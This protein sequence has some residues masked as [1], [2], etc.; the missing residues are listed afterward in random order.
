MSRKKI[1]LIIILLLVVLGGI[2]GVYFYMNGNIKP[3][4]NE[5]VGGFG[6]LVPGE[7]SENMGEI[8]NT[9]SSSDGVIPRLR[10]I[11]RTPVAGYDFVDQG[12]GF[13]IWYVDRGN[14]NVFETATNTLSI[15]RITNTTI[16]KVYEAHIGKGGSNIIL[17]LLDN[18]NTNIQTFIG[19]PKA[20]AGAASSS[21]QTKDLVGTFGPSGINF[22]SLSPLKDRF[23][24]ITGN[25]SGG[26][27]S[28]YPY[29]GTAAN[30]FSH[31]LKKWIPQWVNTNTILLTSAP[32]SKTQNLAYFLN[33]S[34]KAVTKAIGPKNGLV[35][36]SSPDAAYLFYSHNIENNIEA[37]IYNVKLGTELGTANVTIPDKCVWSK[38][39]T[40]LAYCGFPKNLA[41]GSYPDSWYQGKVLFNDEIGSLDMKTGRFSSI[42]DLQDESGVQID[43]INLMLSKDEKYL[44]FTNKNDLT[45]WML[46]L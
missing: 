45:L 26:Q 2:A 12:T 44:L 17:R 25:T 4:D 32:S 14:G 3:A 18:D 33:T 29:L 31:P 22:I 27:G 41:G 38:F 23:F 5:G 6:S 40:S 15:A 1:V 16:P 39:L 28:I 46:E 7:G 19:T 10:Q 34:T 36:S 42:L 24:G 43:A 37:G 30:V 21:D 35:V 11:T 20:K 9:A 13:K 8:E